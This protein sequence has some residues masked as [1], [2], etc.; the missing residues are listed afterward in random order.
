[1]SYVQKARVS[2]FGIDDELKD[3]IKSVYSTKLNSSFYPVP[4]DAV[5]EIVPNSNNPDTDSNLAFQIRNN[6]KKMQFSLNGIFGNLKLSNKAKLVIESINLPNI[7]NNNFRQAKSINNIMLK[8]NGLNSN[9][10]YS[11]TM[12]NKGTIIFNCPVFINA[13]GWGNSNVIT[14]AS[15]PEGVSNPQRTRLNGNNNCHLFINPD[16]QNLYNFNIGII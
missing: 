4:D 15:N 9:N 14:A 12:K 8:L 13:Q 1:M 5:F 16:S 6:T 7:I 10:I 3:D 11:S 2:F